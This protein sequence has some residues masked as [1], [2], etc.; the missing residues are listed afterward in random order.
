MDS[1]LACRGVSGLVGSAD[2]SATASVHPGPRRA[3]DPPS[4]ARLVEIPALDRP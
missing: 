4:V 3:A 1:K 2:S